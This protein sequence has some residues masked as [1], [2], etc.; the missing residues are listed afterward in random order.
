MDGRIGLG[1]LGRTSLG[2]HV[3]LN[4]A[5]AVV[6]GYEIPVKSLDLDGSYRGSVLEF[7]SITAEAFRGHLEVS[8]RFDYGALGS[9]FEARLDGRDLKLEDTMHFEGQPNTE[10]TGDVTL[11]VNASGRTKDL[12][13]TL[14]GAGELSVV[15][16]RIVLV[17]LFRK[18]L[19]KTGEHKQTDRAELTFELHG[20]RVHLSKILILGDLVGIKGK[21]DLYYDGRLNAVVSAGGVERIS[22]ELGPIGQFFGALAGSL[23]KY[24]V[25][26]T[27]QDTKVRVLPLGLGRKKE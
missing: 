16:A 9:P 1:D 8:A 25:T 20:D 18:T 17:E 24:Q 5:R 4:D 13:G 15:N 7:P 23:V 11:T 22:A 14:T 10:Y 27:A 21:G 19:S 12:P 6:G 26:G 3:K 2:F